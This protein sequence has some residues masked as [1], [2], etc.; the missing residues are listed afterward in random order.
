MTLQVVCVS[1]QGNKLQS[2]ADSQV[3]GYQQVEG[4]GGIPSWRHADFREVRFPLCLPFL[5]CDVLRGCH[6]SDSAIAV[7][8]IRP[9][10]LPSLQSGE[11]LAVCDLHVP[12]VHWFATVQ[13]HG[14]CCYS[15]TLGTLVGVML[16]VVCTITCRALDCETVTL[17]VE[18]FKT[19]KKAKMATS[20]EKAGAVAEN[21]RFFMECAFLACFHFR[22]CINICCYAINPHKGA[23]Q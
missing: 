16:R 13:A 14:S 8:A 4:Q 18:S 5:L 21:R 10:E 17:E 2:Y 3:L 1:M 23:S 22:H 19:C 15:P 12:T 7:H 11:K 20:E 6:I 9:L